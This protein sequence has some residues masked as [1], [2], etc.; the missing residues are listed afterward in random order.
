[1]MNSQ[2]RNTY[3]GLSS[4]STI[5]SLT[6]TAVLVGAVFSLSACTSQGVDGSVFKVQTGEKTLL[7]VKKNPEEK[8][9]IEV[10]V[11]KVNFKVKQDQVTDTYTPTTHEVVTPN[12]T[13]TTTTQSEVNY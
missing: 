3:K 5:R 7:D 2:T 1:M 6:A 4:G 12:T 10:E 13:Y 11:P 8:V 9:S